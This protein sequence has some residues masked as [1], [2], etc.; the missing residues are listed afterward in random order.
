[1]QVVRA[2]QNRRAPLIGLDRQPIQNIAASASL[3]HVEL[4]QPLHLALP[5]LVS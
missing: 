5:L 2:R 3:S 1:M 4:A